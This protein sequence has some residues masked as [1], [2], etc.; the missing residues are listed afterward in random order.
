[1]NPE[2]KNEHTPAGTS[3]NGRR[4]T[5]V[6]LATALAIAAWCLLLWSN[7]YAALAVGVVAC[8]AAFIGASGSSRAMRRLATSAII[9]S[10]V[11]IVVVT[12]FIIVLK[13]GLS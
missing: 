11:L 13:I 5:I 8:A 2:D 7:G 9:A 10:L 6:W 1:M 4:H 3:G 12:A